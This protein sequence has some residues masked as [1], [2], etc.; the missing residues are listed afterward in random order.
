MRQ[1]LY[2]WR[3]TRRSKSRARSHFKPRRFPASIW[4]LLSQMDGHNSPI[5]WPLGGHE[6]PSGRGRICTGPDSGPRY[7]I[8]GGRSDFEEGIDFEKGKILELLPGQLEVQYA[9]IFRNPYTYRQGPEPACSP[10]I[11]A[12]EL[13]F[14]QIGSVV[15]N[16]RGSRRRGPSWDDIEESRL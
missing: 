1:I 16:I 5:T 7:K 11:E 10:K 8:N 15:R 6:P 3:F 14:L 2:R 9:I 12:L 4:T 13:W